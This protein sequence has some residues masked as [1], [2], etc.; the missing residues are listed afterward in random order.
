MSCGP[1]SRFKLVK[2]FSNKNITYHFPKVLRGSVYGR[3]LIVLVLRKEY[4]CP[5]NPSELVY[6]AIAI[7]LKGPPTM[8]FYQFA[9]K[10][11][12]SIKIIDCYFQRGVGLDHIIFLLYNRR[13][14][15]YGSSSRRST[16]SCENGAGCA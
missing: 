11:M 8:I 14:L 13:L 5:R 10:H 7:G 15:R 6:V 3:S 12:T 2:I 4:I 9:A 16:C 1:E